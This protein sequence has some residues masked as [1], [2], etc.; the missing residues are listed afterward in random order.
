MEM[1]CGPLR[2]GF[3]I[4]LGG[5][6]APSAS[7]SPRKLLSPQPLADVKGGCGGKAALLPAPPAATQREWIYGQGPLEG[8][9]P[10]ELRRCRWHLRKRMMEWPLGFRVSGPFG[11]AKG[12]Y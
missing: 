9:S 5:S 2:A 7:H 6:A 8:P 10:H 3:V 1:E 4:I 11:Y 12:S